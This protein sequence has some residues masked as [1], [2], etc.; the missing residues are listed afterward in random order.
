M[1]PGVDVVVPTFKRPEALARCLK[2]LEN[3]TIAPASI[4]V[5]DD[6][7]TDKGPAYSRNIG[8]SKGSAPIVAF[9]DDDCVPSK[10]WIASIQKHFENEKV[11]GMEGCVTT[12]GM[13]GQLSDMNPNKKD[14]WNRFKT[15]NMAFRR[16]IIEEIG[17]FDERYYIHREDTDLA[18]RIINSGYTIKWSS[19]CIVHHP[20][21]GGVAR[22]AYDSEQLLYRCD[23]K[24]YVEVAAA[25]ISIS[26]ILNGEWRISRK[27]LCKK[28]RRG[29]IPLT[30][31]ESIILWP[32]A[33]VKALIR[34][35][36]RD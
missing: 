6:S 8:L 13:D 9:T 21:R 12:I 14:K 29:V 26:N 34:K 31:S 33:F 27:E 10:N 15:A 36:S 22:V 17:G 28:Q 20:D 19:K 30:I 2:A 11:H 23:P 32:N 4:E 7:T 18:W 24:K 5:I 16:S 25:S 35:I 1:K 3:Q